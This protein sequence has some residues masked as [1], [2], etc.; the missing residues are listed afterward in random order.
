[1][2]SRN[3]ILLTMGLF[4]LF[5]VVGWTVYG[6]KK[7]SSKSTWEYRYAVN[8]TVDQ[9]NSLGAEGWELVGFEFAE[10]NHR[11]FYFKRATNP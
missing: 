8:Q 3:S 11:H 10:Y 9:L 7:S 6:Q 4:L 1:M 5:V 2:R